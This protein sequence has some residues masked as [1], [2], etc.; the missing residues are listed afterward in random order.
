MPQPPV[1][2]RIP[3][4]NKKSS[5]PQEGQFG[6]PRST[7]KSSLPQKGQIGPQF[8]SQ[9]S[10]ANSSHVKVYENVPGNFLSGAG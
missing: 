9:A 3:L 5:P 10:Q 7:E 6:T 1:T 8:S 4:G 2:T